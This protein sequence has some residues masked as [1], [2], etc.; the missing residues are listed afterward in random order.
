MLDVQRMP[1]NRE[2]PID[3]VGV[4]GIRCPITVLDK[5]RGEQQ[6]VASVCMTVNLP[7]HFKGTH[8][9]RFIEILNEH[10]G[11]MDIRNFSRLLAEVKRR[12]EAHSA[13]IVLDFPYFITKRAP[14]SGAE[15][16]MDYD[17]TYSASIDQEDRQDV[18]LTVRVPIATVCPCSKEISDRGAHNQRGI[19]TLSIRFRHFIWLEDLIC[20]IESAGSG[21]LFA[22]L[23]REDEKFCTEHAYDNPRFVED[24]VREIGTRLRDDSNVVW[25][26][27]EAENIESIHNHNAYACIE[28][29]RH[30]LKRPVTRG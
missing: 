4:K 15:G 5:D 2:I 24:V 18:T 27:V 21:E 23:K 22:L 7:E 8:M 19:V 6:T 29:D 10:R 1:D 13:H 17:V 12:L 25:F 30:G 20:L 16:M 26:K 9:S 28:L 14:V 3:K 11:S